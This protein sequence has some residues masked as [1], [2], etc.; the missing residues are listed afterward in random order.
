MMTNE[1]CDYAY[2]FLMIGLVYMGVWYSTC[3]LH[4]W[5]WN[6]DVINVLL[7]NVDWTQAF[8]KCV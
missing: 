6:E 1:V 5:A 7:C 8:K 3:T 2:D 4:K